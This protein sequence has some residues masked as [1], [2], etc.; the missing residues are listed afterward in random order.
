M[1]PACLHCLAKANQGWTSAN[2]SRV[3]HTAAGM[4]DVPA[5]ANKLYPCSQHSWSC[6]S[7]RLSEGPEITSEIST[8]TICA[9]PACPSDHLGFTGLSLQGLKALDVLK[10]MKSAGHAPTLKTYALVLASL[11]SQTPLK[12][13]SIAANEQVWERLRVPSFNYTH[14][15]HPPRRLSNVNL[16]GFDHAG[17]CRPRAERGDKGIWF[18]R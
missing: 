12:P 2:G 13:G 10:A 17:S 1:S 16:A 8:L 5:G 3:Q 7:W 11:Q 14:C 15:T 9:S 6:V 18:E 4:R